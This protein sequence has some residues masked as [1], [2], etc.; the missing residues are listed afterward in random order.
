MEGDRL[1]AIE[2]V[3]PAVSAS[4]RDDE[5]VVMAG[6]LDDKCAGELGHLDMS[7]A[8]FQ[9]AAAWAMCAGVSPRPPNIPDLKQILWSI[10]AVM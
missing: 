7:D 8:L 10:V 9:N 6:A 1:A 3:R 4:G 5:G 2:A